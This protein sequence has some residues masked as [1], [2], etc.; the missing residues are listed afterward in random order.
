MI[1]YNELRPGQFIEYEDSVFV[2]LEANFLRMQQ[3]KPVMKAKLKDIISGKVK[4][5]NFQ[6]SD[7]LEEAE[8]ERMKCRFLYKNKEQYWFD[9]SGNPKNRFFFTP[10]QLGKKTDFL[11]SN[12]EV[13]ALTWKEKIINID[14]PIKMDFEVIEAPPAIKGDT[15][16]GGGKLVTLETGAK[17]TVPF[18]VGEGDMVRVNTETGDYVERV[19]KA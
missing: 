16:S 13:T 14:I 17:I 6:G 4:E 1:A 15:A 3:R 8:L 9:E 19:G 2:V 18:F 12:T 10:D 5:V 11:K 7:N